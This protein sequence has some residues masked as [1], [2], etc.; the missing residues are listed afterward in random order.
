MSRESAARRVVFA[1]CALLWAGSSA[2][3]FADDPA[4]GSGIAPA[5]RGG[6]SA[7]IALFASGP[8][9]QGWARALARQWG[10]LE[11]DPVAHAAALPPRIARGRMQA[12]ARIEGLLLD[13]R[14][15]AASLREADALASL[16]AAERTAEGAADVPGIAAWMAEVQLQLGAV[17]AQAGALELAEAAFRRAA[18]LEPGRQLLPAEAA[19][20]VVARCARIHTE[21]AAAPAGS[22]EVQAFVG[23]DAAPALHGGASSPASARVFLDDVELG[24][25]PVRARAVVGRH[26]LRVEASGHEGYGAFIDVLPGERPALAVQLTPLPQ[27]EL[28]RALRQAVQSGMLTRVPAVLNAASTG[29]RSHL[30]AVAVVETSESGARA[31]IVRCDRAGCGAPI[32]ATREQPVALG[33]GELT[34]E[35]LIAAR[36]WL[37]SPRSRSASDQN[38]PLWR[39]WYLWGG[40]ALAVAAGA[41]AVGF[42]AQ[43]A[44]AH[45]LRV[46][47]DPGAL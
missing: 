11:A 26:V 34:G 24:V 14:G 46:E 20:D 4:S 37:S 16:A 25:A 10:P 19:P 28:A 18:T 5:L 7:R 13:A 47:V 29:A 35:R 44:P 1:C 6:A 41:L 38:T 15:Q 31:L 43:P 45:R 22:F 32:R 23:R 8:H 30:E 39:R 33:S 42:A 3:V 40:T 21:L 9:A 36:T 2:R 12:L 17:A 27:L